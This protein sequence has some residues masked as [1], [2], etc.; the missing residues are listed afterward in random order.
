MLLDNLRHVTPELLRESLP[1]ASQ[2]FP[3]KWLERQEN[4]TPNDVLLQ[5][6]IQMVSARGAAHLLRFGLDTGKNM[7]PLAEAI[8]G[9][10]RVLDY[11][12]KSGVFLCGSFVY[13]L[14]AL[15]DV[16]KNL[17]RIKNSHDRLPRLMTDQWK[18]SLYELLVACSQIRLG[19]VELLPENGEPIPDMLIDN[20]LY[21]ECKAR[22]EY[23]NKIADFIKLF[24]THVVHK[25]FHETTSIGNGL[26]IEID[27]RDHSGIT[28]IPLLLR[29]MLSN[30]RMRRTTPRLKI[31]LTPWQSG[32]Y[33]LPYPMQAH[34]AELWQWL[35]NFREWNDWHCVHPYAEFKIENSSN[36]IVSEVQR[37]VLVCVRSLP[38]Q[39]VVPNIRSTIK[40]AYSRQLRSYGPGVVRMLIRSDLYGIGEN[41]TVAKIKMDLDKIALSLL[42]EC[43]G[44]VAV[45]FDI[46]TP[47]E[48]GTLKI[49]YDSAGACRQE[50]VG[51]KQF[52]APGILVI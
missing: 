1:L 3:A 25:I 21:L 48:R 34:S 41:A 39:K 33:R 23:E 2:L 10:R 17:D 11:E 13:L 28:E 19:N 14:L 24:Q 5:T 40:N 35:M 50:T 16:A 22:T 49:S 29:E 42:Q 52:L 51:M 32:P 37:P 9:V 38:L 45:R 27:V 7:H 8:W 44:L 15:S 4:R 47:P 6:S 18:S 20:T 46:V 30:Q 36:M 31:K 12:E 43:S 26:K